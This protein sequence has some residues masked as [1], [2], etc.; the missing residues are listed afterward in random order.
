MSSLIKCFQKLMCP[1]SSIA[2]SHKPRLVQTFDSLSTAQYGIY[3]LPVARNLKV[4]VS[5]SP[6]RRLFRM[7]VFSLVVKGATMARIVSKDSTTTK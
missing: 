6:G 3:Y 7:Y 1:C 2:P 5:F 4:K